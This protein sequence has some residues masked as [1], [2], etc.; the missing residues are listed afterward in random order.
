MTKRDY[1]WI[2]LSIGMIS[3][4]IMK[5]NGYGLDIHLN[6]EE[7]EKNSRY[8]NEHDLNKEREA[9][10][11]KSPEYREYRDWCI[12]KGLDFM[13]REKDRDYRNGGTFDIERDQKG[14]LCNKDRD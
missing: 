9:A 5:L 11:L 2:A 4:S 12:K 7:I 8:Q 14:S 3:F 13:Q 10:Y 6:H 1:V